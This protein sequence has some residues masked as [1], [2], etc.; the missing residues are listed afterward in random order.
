MITNH[1]L[2]NQTDR[3]HKTYQ[4]LQDQIFLLQILDTPKLFNLIF[5]QRIFKQNM[6]LAFSLKI[7]LFTL[8]LCFIYFLSPISFDFFK[9]PRDDQYHIVVIISITSAL[10]LIIGLKHLINNRR[11]SKLLNESYS[12]LNQQFFNIN[13]FSYYAF[14][15]DLSPFEAHYQWQSLVCNTKKNKPNIHLE[16]YFHNLSQA[17]NLTYVEFNHRLK[18]IKQRINENK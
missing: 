14:I 10:F 2:I 16:N 8:L 6:F 9:I 3:D 7:F 11:K 15:N 4:S 1:F 5:Q 13:I 17:S 12:I 18:K